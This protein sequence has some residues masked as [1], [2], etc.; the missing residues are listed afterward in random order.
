MTIPV[1]QASRA[2]PRPRPALRRVGSGSVSITASAMGVIAIGNSLPTSSR[3]RYGIGGSGA[4][5][6]HSMVVGGLI[7]K[8]HRVTAGGATS[9]DTNRSAVREE[10]DAD[11]IVD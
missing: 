11:L 1:D 4:S 3:K 5:Y 2:V 8:H 7:V 6:S 9:L 10:H